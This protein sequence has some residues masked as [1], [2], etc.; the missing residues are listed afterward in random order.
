MLKFTLIAILIFLMM[1]HYPIFAYS[2]IIQRHLFIPPI[3]HSLFLTFYLFN[4]F[5]SAKFNFLS[6]TSNFNSIVRNSANKKST[7]GIAPIVSITKPD[8]I[9]LAFA[10]LSFLYPFLSL[11]LSPS[12]SLL[13]N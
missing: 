7:F 3:H 13:F 4:L 5:R 6:V 10:I 2:S 11:L 8:F 12:A 9:I 1:H